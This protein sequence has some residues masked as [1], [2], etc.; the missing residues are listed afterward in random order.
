MMR[1]I[2]HNV[3][4]HEAG[5]WLLAEHYRFKAGDILIERL[6]GFENYRGGSEIYLAKAFGECRDVEVYL[7]QR[8]QVLYAGA[9]AES[10]DA[11]GNVDSDK[12]CAILTKGTGKNDFDKSQELIHVLRSLLHGVPEHK[13]ACREQIDDLSKTIWEAA[14]GVVEGLS[15]LIEDIA[16][17]LMERTQSSETTFGIRERSIRDI[18]KI[19]EWLRSI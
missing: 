15:P 17:H 5:H 16:K 9:I 2:L 4:R 18:P 3:V 8:I 14:I 7:N 11:T 1:N 6:D 13:T 12:A 19:S 10:I